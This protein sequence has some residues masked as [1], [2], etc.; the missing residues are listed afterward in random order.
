MLT[1]GFITFSILDCITFSILGFITYSIPRE[2]PR[3]V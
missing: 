3:F 1:L 2:G